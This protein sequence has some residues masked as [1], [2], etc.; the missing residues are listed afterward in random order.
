MLD[1]YIEWYKKA[2]RF[3]TYDM[4]HVDMVH[5]K[6][7]DAFLIKQLKIFTIA[8]RRFFEDKVIVRCSALAYYSLMAIVPLL[9]LLFAIAKGLGI[10]DLLRIFLEQSF[11]EHNEMIEFLLRFADNA[12]ANT[13]TGVLSVL[14]IAFLMWSIIKVLN[15]IESAFNDVWQVK[16]P[17]PL[18]RKFTDYLAFIL[19]VPIVIAFSSGISLQV[20]YH[21]GSWIQGIPVLEHAGPLFGTL[22]PFVLVF[23]ALTFVYVAVPFTK[24]RTGPAFIAA[25]IAGVAFQLT[26]NMYIFSQITVSKY[27]TIYGAFAV[28]P[29]LC[30]WLQISWIII[31]FGAELA[32]AYQNLERYHYEATSD[33]ISPFQREVS[34]ILIARLIAKRFVN[35]ESPYTVAELTSELNLPYRVIRNSIEDLQ[36][37][38]L[39]SEV[40]VQGKHKARYHA[41]QPALDVHSM[42]IASVYHALSH[43]GQV[44]LAEEDDVDTSRIAE[45]L[46]KHFEKFERSDENKL[47]IDI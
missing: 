37:C 38:K 28:L 21:I 36:Q 6:R 16:R 41:Y 19:I 13:R 15:N 17:R 8:F 39:L 25:V 45:I 9:A 7:R 43:L 44:A 1:K 3:I 26:Q 33:H 4:W 22:V 12:I 40:N 47:L 32:F 5:Y 24:V 42:S 27:G 34:G 30:L 31:L 18:S 23:F 2:F 14:G 10:S 35:G 20:R 29:L 46:T 11:G